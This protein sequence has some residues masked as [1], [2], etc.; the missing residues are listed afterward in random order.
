[1]SRYAL[2]HFDEV[3]GDIL[4]NENSGTKSR[5]KESTAI[6]LNHKD[7]STVDNTFQISKEGYMAVLSCD[8][9]TNVLRAIPQQVISYSKHEMKLFLFKLGEDRY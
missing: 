7:E 6:L 2:P 5:S 3:F 9:L 1:M 4:G 8:P